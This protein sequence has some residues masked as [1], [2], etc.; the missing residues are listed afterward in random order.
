MSAARRRPA[1]IR[2]GSSPIHCRS[3]SNGC[4]AMIADGP[5]CRRSRNGC[6]TIPAAEPTRHARH[7]PKRQHLRQ[8]HHHTN[9]KEH[10]CVTSTNP[11]NLTTCCTTCADRSSTRPPAW[12]SPACTCS[13]STSAIPRRS[14]SARRT[15]SSTTCPGNSATRKATPRPRACSRRAR[16]S[17]STRSS[18]TCPMS[19]SKTSTPATAS[20]S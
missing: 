2:S 14:A 5:T 19:A 3:T 11:P 18:R 4:S 17:C 10:P 15:R 7:H 16:R 9:W 8:R 6:R 12:S 13:S 1:R 20:A